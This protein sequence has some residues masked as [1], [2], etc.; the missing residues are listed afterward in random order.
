MAISR[1]ERNRLSAIQAANDAR[2]E[3]HPSEC[4]HPDAQHRRAKALEILWELGAMAA[5]AA[6]PAPERPTGAESR[7]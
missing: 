3:I 6:H 5:P 4:D 7:A 2:L 1:A